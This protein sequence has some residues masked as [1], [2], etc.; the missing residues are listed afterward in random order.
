MSARCS[1]VNKNVETAELQSRT[2]CTRYQL[3]FYLF[4]SLSDLKPYVILNPGP[5]SH[6]NPVKTRI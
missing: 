1:H 3:V 2:G 5:V 4:K 6:T